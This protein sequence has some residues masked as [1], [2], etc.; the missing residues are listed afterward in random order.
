MK[1]MY[2]PHWAL[3]RNAPLTIV[4]GGRGRGKTYGWKEHCLK[5]S[6][7]TAWVSRTD[8]E[9]SKVAKGYLGDLPH[10]QTDFKLSWI[11]EKEDSIEEKTIKSKTVYPSIIETATG[12]ERVSFASLNVQNKG[13]PFLR[14]KTLVFDEFLI[15]EGTSNRYLKNEVSIFYD[16]LQTIARNKPDFR[17]VLIGNLIDWYNPYF[18]E[19]GIEKIDMSKRFTWI[20]KPDI[21]LEILP[22]TE[23]WTEAYNN[24][25]FKRIVD[26]TQ[27]DQYMAGDIPL[28]NFDIEIKPHPP[29]ARYMFNL[30]SGSNILGVWNHFNYWYVTN[31]MIDKSKGAYVSR[32]QEAG[33]NRI[34]DGKV[35]T[36]IKQLVSKNMLFSENASA[37]VKLLEWLR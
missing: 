25:A 35:K 30:I 20:K 21:L 8:K 2:N 34:F 15:L 3:S 28:V 6:P 33:K 10:R 31:T 1:G 9:A 19:W 17:A 18:A 24:S 27:Y 36:Q 26:G 32:F 23:A 22:N 5:S 37:R 11:A 14:T 16:L 12:E 13:I 4:L 7:H 29:F